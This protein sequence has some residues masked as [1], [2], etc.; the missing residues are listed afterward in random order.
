MTDTF[1]AALAELAPQIAKL[2]DGARMIEHR[3]AVRGPKH[4]AVQINLARAQRLAEFPLRILLVKLDLAVAAGEN[5]YEKFRWYSA[6]AVLVS[7]NR[8][9][10][11]GQRLRWPRRLLRKSHGQ[12]TASKL[13][14]ND[15][16][17]SP[18]AIWHSGSRLS[19]Q[20]RHSSH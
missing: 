5:S 2:I 9:C 14:S 16:G 10:R 13:L 3:N 18:I 19:Q 7:G 15:S 6:T 11:N 17:S 20:M 8:A 12:W 1:L 4:Q